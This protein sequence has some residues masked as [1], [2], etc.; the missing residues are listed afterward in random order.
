QDGPARI[1]AEVTDRAGNP[2]RADTSVT[3][4]ITVP[5][6]TIDTVSGDDI[7]NS[8][9][10]NQALLITG[11]AVGAA[12]GDRV[13]VTLNGHDYLTVLDASGNWSIGV[14]AAD[15]KALGEQT[16]DIIV[17]VTD[18][19]G[20]SSEG[21]HDISVNLA[22]PE[23]TINTIAGDDIINSTEKGQD[24]ILS[25]TAT[26]VK[27]GT[28][29]SVTLNGKTYHATVEDNGS[30][31]TTV[32]AADVGALGEARYEVVASVT[33]AAGNSGN[34][35]HT[36]IVDSRA[37]AV[38][39]D[40][41]AGDDVINA[42]EAAAGQNISGRVINAEVG[43]T[44]TVTIAGKE[45][46]TTVQPGLSWTINVPTGDLKALGNGPLTVTA[47]VTNGHQN[48]GGGERD[49]TIS[50]GMPGVRIDTIAGDDVINRIEH[51]QDLIVTGSSDGLKAG[52]AV[53]VTLNG[54]DYA[55]TVLADGTWSAAVPK[56]DVGE[57][58]AGAVKVTVSG[59]SEAGNP[60][61]VDRIARVD[62]AEVAISIDNVTQDN[63]LNAAE[64]GENLI[65]SGSTAGV[66]SGQKVTI[67]FG[68]KIYTAVVNNGSWSCTVPAADLAGQRDGSASLQVS[69]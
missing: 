66:E 25:G 38:V 16:H 17:T 28:E 15:V 11:K 61:Q 48:S 57:L 52:A 43:N 49:F 60:V 46:I 69:V 6:I 4:D 21:K 10:H 62:L 58:A 31:H 3:V 64:R 59:T 2:A 5:Q 1:T 7:I 55:A 14:P 63:V 29:V 9:E 56:A 39:I 12:A 47:T 24:L 40:R 51:G 65:L 26:G 37:P 20:N 36:A 23:L 50:A 34:T 42:A 13:T 30:W 33:D 19:A 44:V 35:T 18:R 41:I 8:A 53:T 32:P 22:Q 54:K 45:Y 27:P 68:D 67:A